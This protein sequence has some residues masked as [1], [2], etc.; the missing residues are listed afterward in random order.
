[1]DDRHLLGLGNGY[2]DEILWTAR[3]HPRRPAGSLDGGQWDE[4]AGALRDVLTAAIAAG[5]E[6]GF[7]IPRERRA[8]S[9]GRSTTTPASRAR[10]A[11][12]RSPA[13]SRASARPTSVRPVSP[14][15][16]PA[17]SVVVLRSSPCPRWRAQRER[18]DLAAASWRAAI[19]L[20]ESLLHRQV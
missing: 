1:M 13:S 18:M 20:G 16:A 19:R 12:T 7:L 15:D 2:S 17:L 4:L 14:S 11:G 3:L 8:A 9:A 5:G 6:E 10:G